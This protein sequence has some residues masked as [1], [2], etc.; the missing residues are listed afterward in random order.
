MSLK[1]SLL[2]LL[3]FCIVFCCFPL[4]SFAA[5]PAVAVE[6]DLI[7]LPY[8]TLYIRGQDSYPMSSQ[9]ETWEEYILDFDGFSMQI[10]FSDGSRHLYQFAVHQ[11]EF[12]GELVRFDSGQRQNHWGTG[13]NTVTVWYCGLSLRFSVTVQAQNDGSFTLTLTQLPQQ[14][15]YQ[16]NTGGSWEWRWDDSACALVPYYRYEP[17]LSG[18]AVTLEAPPGIVLQNDTEPCSVSQEHGSL[19]LFAAV[20]DNHEY[21]FDRDGYLFLGLPVA[22]ETHQDT[23]PWLPGTNRITMHY[24]GQQ[25]SFTVTLVPEK[26]AQNAPERPLLQTVTDSCITIKEQP[27]CEFSINGSAWQT[28]TLFSGLSPNRSYSICA[29]YAE[30]TAHPASEASEFLRVTTLR[31]VIGGTLSISGTAAFGQTLSPDLHA[32]TPAGATLHYYWRCG[33]TVRS[34]AKTYTVAKADIGQPLHLLV[35]GYGDFDGLCISAA[36]TP[37]KAT[38]LPPGAPELLLRTSTSVTL[39]TRSDCQYRVNSGAWQDS[40]VFSGLSPGKSYRFS[41]RLRETDTHFLSA[42]GTELQVTTLSIALNG[43]PKIIGTAE[44]GSLLTAETGTLRP[45]DTALQYSWECGSIVVGTGKTYTVKKADIGQELL[46]RVTGSGSGTGNVVSAAQTVQKA[47][48][49]AVPTVPQL[50]SATETKLTIQTKK[51]LEYRLNSGAWQSDGVFSGLKA[52][53]AYQITVREAETATHSAS[54]VSM[55]L[56]VNTKA[57][58]IPAL[59]SKTYAIQGSYLSR[60]PVETTAA[61]LLANLTDS[62]SVQLSR[63]AQT[64][65]GSKLVGTGTKIQRMQDKKVI[66]TLTAIVTGDINGDGKT[67]LTDF[68]QMKEYLLG[69]RSLKG[70][71][72]QA[73]DLNGDNTVTL[74][75]FVRLKSHLLGKKAIVALAYAGG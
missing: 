57:R 38:P 34:E 71:Y 74:T 63:D 68:V 26:S 70:A 60:L 72:L 12:E 69:K 73:A 64:L 1:R 44:Y 50:L 25:L 29:R 30:T 58:Q 65:T 51:G 31:T 11:Y 18:L 42:G 67:T 16:E 20:T 27:G 41:L 75:D 10:L 36:V 40:P 54:P 21:L 2:L 59:A 66:Q 8:K 22:F 23:Q 39:Q 13:E 43:T 37:A 53:T 61:K 35:I 56:T 9:E 48:R 47:Q 19:L 6:L 28:Q 49:T 32:L 62:S 14:T 4:L 52:D 5:E 33:D 7:S 17:Q 55:A 46:L 45:A 15:V 24:A 3:A